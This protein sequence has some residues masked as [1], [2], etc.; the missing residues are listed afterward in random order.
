MGF[1]RWDIVKIPY[2]LGERPV[3]EHRPA[4]VIVAGELFKQHGLLWVL[5]ITSAKNRGWPGDI[6]VGD[7]MAAGL[8]VPCVIRTAKMMTVEGR[9][10]EVIG[11][12][13]GSQR[14]Q[15]GERVFANMGLAGAPAP[16]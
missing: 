2:P 10:A 9:D 13:L 1:K 16:A 12:L 11:A 4:L 7:V 5:M 3:G 6:E 14:Q 15:V 8:G